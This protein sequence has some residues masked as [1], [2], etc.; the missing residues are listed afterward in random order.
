[1]YAVSMQSNKQL[2][3]SSK[4]NYLDNHV[5]VVYMRVL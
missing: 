1:M 4:A 3:W 5:L 2:V